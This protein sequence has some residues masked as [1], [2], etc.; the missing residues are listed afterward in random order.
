MRVEVESGASFSW[1]PRAN[2]EDGEGFS[3]NCFF[4][5]EP[6]KGMP[7]FWKRRVKTGYGSIETGKPLGWTRKKPSESWKRFAE[8]WK[9]IGETG[10]RFPKSRERYAQERQ[11]SAKRRKLFAPEKLP[12]LHRMRLGRGGSQFGVCP[13][14]RCRPS[15]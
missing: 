7:G 6:G 9:Q 13:D 12:G 14:S 11:L 2:A 10:Q 1:E 8:T 4:S 3:R 5:G 15:R